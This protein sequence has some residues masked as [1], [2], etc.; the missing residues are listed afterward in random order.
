MG[1][2]GRVDVVVKSDDPDPDPD[3]EDVIEDEND[4]FDRAVEE[5]WKS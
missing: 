1:T 5:V 3:I 4:E 2:I